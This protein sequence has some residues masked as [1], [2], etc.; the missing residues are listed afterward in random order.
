[1]DALVKMSEK[2]Q[3]VVPREI[4]EEEGFE[5]SDRFV[6]VPIED[7]VAFKRIDLDVEEEYRELA[8]K[9]R[10]RFREEGVEKEEVDEAV[11]N[12]RE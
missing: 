4:R 10:E 11:E 7:G 6:A 9:V 5:P 8:G 2:G 3:L 12:A 1:M